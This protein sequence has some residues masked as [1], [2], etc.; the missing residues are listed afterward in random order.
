ME[1]LSKY[2]QGKYKALVS[3]L[4]R[5]EFRLKIANLFKNYNSIYFPV[6]LDHRGRLYCT[7]AYFNYPS[8]DLAKALILFSIPGII[9]N[10]YLDE[11]KYLKSYG[12]NCFGGD[13]SKGSVEAKLK[14]VDDNLHNIINFENGVL[15]NRAKEKF[16]FIA[17]CIEYKRYNQFLNDDNLLE[18][19][20]YLPIQLDA[21]CN[22]FQHLAM[23]SQESKLYRVLNLTNK[24][25][26]PKDF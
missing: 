20:T 24:E 12:V 13:I 15:I 14:R 3:N 8:S 2:K 17:F 10:N 18:F 25:K 1:Y 7:P 23:L 5:Q 6:K 9:N 19:K 22:G 16:L 11:I 21:T 4:V 26:Y